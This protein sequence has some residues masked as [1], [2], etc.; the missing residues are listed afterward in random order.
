MNRRRVESLRQL[1]AV[2]V[3]SAVGWLLLK[4]DGYFGAQTESAG[5]IVST[6]QIVEPYKG[7]A[8]LVRCFDTPAL[9]NSLEDMADYDKP[10]TLNFDQASK[11][12]N[13]EP[14]VSAELDDKLLSGSVKVYVD[15][16]YVMNPET[17]IVETVEGSIG[18]GFLT[19]DPE[20]QPVVVTAAHVVGLAIDDPSKI[21]VVDAKGNQARITDGCYE[22][23]VNGEMI[24]TY[25]KNSLLPANE[26]QDLAVLRLDKQLKTSNLPLAN[27]QPEKGDWLR[28]VNNA[29]NSSLDPA[30]TYSTLA[31]TEPNSGDYHFQVLSGIDPKQ[32][33]LADGEN[34]YEYARPGASGGVVA[35]QNGEVVCLLNSGGDTTTEELQYY[36]MSIGGAVQSDERWKPVR[37]VCSSTYA[38]RQVLQSPRY[39]NDK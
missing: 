15:P 39:R 36:S 22:Y 18:G 37:S 11:K 32:T 7:P 20:G 14:E 33:S 4:A 12:Y 31:I 34:R 35:N 8:K 13:N 29:P 26:F 6:F 30:I 19:K 2:G 5:D 38:I 27:V 3:V 25:V 9:V 21:H 23:S 24:D 1:A 17:K 16:T 28:A 10:I